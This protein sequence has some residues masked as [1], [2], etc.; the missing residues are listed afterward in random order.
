MRII[1]EWLDKDDNVLFRKDDLPS[2]NIGDSAQVSPVVPK[3]QTNFDLGQRLSTVTLQ[4]GIIGVVEEAGD[5]YIKEHVTSFRIRIVDD[6]PKETCSTCA[7]EY[8]RGFNESCVG[9][10]V[11]SRWKLKPN[12]CECCTKY[13]HQ[14]TLSDNDY[15]YKV[16]ANCLPALVNTA[17]SP[18]QF[19]NLIR[20][21]H[22]TKEHLLHGDFYDD[23]TGEALQPR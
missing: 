1:I 20:N 17:L 22:T 16:C 21:G 12:L 7:H 3:F 4:K 9:C 2:V 13:P 14:Y 6:L 23:E 19:F 10:N 11:K 15:Q 5:R 18:T 8:P